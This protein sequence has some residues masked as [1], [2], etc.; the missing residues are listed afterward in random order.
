MAAERLH[1]P[2]RH[3]LCLWRKNVHDLSCRLLCCCCSCVGGEDKELLPDQSQRGQSGERDTQL[4]WTCLGDDQGISGEGEASAIHIT[5]EDLGLA[6]PSFNLTKE[7]S[8]VQMLSAV[9]PS[10]N[11]VS[12]VRRALKKKRLLKPLSSLPLQQRGDQPGGDQLGGDQSGGDQSGGD[13]SGGDQPGGDQPVGDQPGGEQTKRRSPASEEERGAHQRRYITGEG[14]QRE[15][16]Q[17]QEIEVAEEEDSILFDTPGG[18]GTGS[19]LTPPVIN[20]IPPTPSD[21]IDEDQF[22]DD[23][24][25]DEESMAHTYGTGSDGSSNTAGDRE[26]EEEEE[27]MEDLDQEPEEE[28]T[29]RD[30]ETMERQMVDGSKGYLG[31]PDQEVLLHA[32]APEREGEVRSA[33]EKERPKP[34]FLCSAYQVAPL[35]EYPRKRSFNSSINLLLFTEHN[36]DDWSNA[37]ASCH[38]LLRAELRLLPLRTKMEASI[39]Q[40]LV[41]GYEVV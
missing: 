20:L 34:S 19:L 2:Q 25:S 10:S 26:E 18:S 15:A 22:F 21:V 9:S 13:Q 39:Y 30:A 12:A 1:G 17:E 11:S 14:E 7:V 8:P 4:E 23:I 40:R 35:P 37:D 24:I 27:R 5:V 6:N 33:E 16:M 41:R 29:K 36:L 32:P 28:G 3:R 31:E 38:E